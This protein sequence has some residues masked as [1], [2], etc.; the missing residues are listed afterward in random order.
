M[1]RGLF[2]NQDNPINII[3]VAI[4][5]ACLTNLFVTAIKATLNNLPFAFN[6]R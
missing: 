6:R 4:A 2:F 3:I 1:N 5:N